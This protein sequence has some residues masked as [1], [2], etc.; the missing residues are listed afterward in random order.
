[1]VVFESSLVLRFVDGHPTILRAP[2]LERLQAHTFASCG[3]GDGRSALDFL[4]SSDDLG[5][6]KLALP[7][8]M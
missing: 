3:L 5:F 8:H 1:M 4:D 6:R 7:R 2:T